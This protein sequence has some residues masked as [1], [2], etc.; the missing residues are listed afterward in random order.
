[1]LRLIALDGSARELKLAV[2]TGSPFMLII[3][4]EP[5]SALNHGKAVRIDTNFGMLDGAWFQLSMPE[6]EVFETV[7]GYESEE[8][9]ESIKASDPALDGLV[10]LP[11]LRLLEYG[12]NADEFWIRPRSGV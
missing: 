12:G 10:G 1:M 2:D 11:V 9:V 6:F 4:P 5:A 3:S 8:V 7:C